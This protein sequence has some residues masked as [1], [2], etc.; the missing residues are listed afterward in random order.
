MF[1]ATLCFFGAGGHVSISGIRD[2]LDTGVQHPLAG[3][4]D[5]DVAVKD[6]EVDDDVEVTSLVILHGGDGFLIPFLLLEVV[7]LIGFFPFD[8]IL[9]TNQF[10]SFIV[11]DI[12]FPQWS[13]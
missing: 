2:F 9:R 4:V 5:V 12:L 8:A 10:E 7:L 11:T 1:C 13:M 6:I 3:I